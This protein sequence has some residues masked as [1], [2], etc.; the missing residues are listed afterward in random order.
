MSNNTKRIDKV[1]IKRLIDESGTPDHLGKY[2]STPGDP[3]KTI[4]RQATADWRPGEYRFFIAA[5]CP[6]ETGILS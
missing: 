5:N 3:D 2:S 1:V 4:D 6:E